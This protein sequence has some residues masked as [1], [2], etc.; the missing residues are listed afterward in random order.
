MDFVI[1]LP[2]S[3]NRNNNNYDSILLIIN[4]LKKI[5]YYKPFK[6]TINV[7]SLAEIIINMMV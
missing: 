3:T 5:V 1:G 2:M 7:S 4:R 6:I